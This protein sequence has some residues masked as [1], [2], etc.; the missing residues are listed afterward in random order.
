MLLSYSMTMHI[1]SDF[2]QSRIKVYNT[3]LLY[4]FEMRICAITATIFFLDIVQP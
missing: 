1:T 3:N 2:G 4:V